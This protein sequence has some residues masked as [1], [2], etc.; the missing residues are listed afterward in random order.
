[1]LQPHSILHETEALIP[2]LGNNMAEEEKISTVTP[3]EYNV[4]TPKS[5]KKA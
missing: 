1:M 4:E 3:Q 5:E 2:L